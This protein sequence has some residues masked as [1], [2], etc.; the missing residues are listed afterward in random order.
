MNV[1]LACIATGVGANCALLWLCYRAL[2]VISWHLHEMRKL[3]ANTAGI[4][5]GSARSA[6]NYKQQHYTNQTERAES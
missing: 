4:G 3:S 2:G 5:A 6:S 1:I